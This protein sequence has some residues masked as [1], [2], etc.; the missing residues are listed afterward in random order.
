M[1]TPDVIQA[2]ATE[3]I[4]ALASS[5]PHPPVTSTIDGF[6]LEDAYEVLREIAR[7]RTASGWVPVGRKIGFTNRTIWEIFNVTAPLWAHVWDRTIEHAPEGTATVSL[8]GLPEPRIEPEVVFGLRGPVPD[9]DDP[10]VILGAVEWV[11]PGFE[12][13]QS[14]FPGWSFTLPD[15]TAAFGLHGRLVVGP[16]VD[17]DGD[18][19]SLATELARFEATL[20]RDDSVVDHGRGSDVLDSPALALGYL[21][22]VV[23]DQ[24]RQP[25]LAAGEIIT[26]GTITSAWPVEPGQRWRSD[27]GSLG[28]SGLDVTFT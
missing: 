3:L 5:T 27:Y 17:V 22:R 2:T 1:Q 13:V 19:A 21:G 16:R 7:V 9:S 4:D 12:I 26:T 28:L 6:D 15:A 23:A 18:L 10:V 24:P 11:A 25:P 8:D 20:S 14:V